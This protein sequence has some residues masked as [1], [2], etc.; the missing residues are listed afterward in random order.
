MR[1]TPHPED[2]ELEA[3]PKPSRWQRWRHV[4][5]DTLTRAAL[6]LFMAALGVQIALDLV[7]AAVSAAQLGW[8]WLK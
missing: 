1:R 8:T 6:V 3:H 4:D 5:L 7:G 2:Q